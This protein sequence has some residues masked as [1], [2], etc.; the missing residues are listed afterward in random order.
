MTYYMSRLGVH[1]A[2]DEIPATAPI[3]GSTS[4]YLNAYR[5]HLY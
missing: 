2:N 5:T 3:Q 1:L 4:R